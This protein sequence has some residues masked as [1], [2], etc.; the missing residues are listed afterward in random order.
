[1][2]GIKPCSSF[3]CPRSRIVGIIDSLHALGIHVALRNVRGP[4]VIVLTATSTVDL[5][6]VAEALSETDEK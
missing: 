2:A 5:H 4:E 3:L 6:N 1:V